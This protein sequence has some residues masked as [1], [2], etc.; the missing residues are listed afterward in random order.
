VKAGVPIDPKFLDDFYAR[1]SD[2][3]LDEDTK[4]WGELIELYANEERRHHADKTRRLWVGPR[5]AGEIYSH[6][7]TSTLFIICFV[8]GGPKSDT[9]E[10]GPSG[11]NSQVSSK[12]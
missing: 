9:R 1:L 4:F 3:V 8:A 5:D 6:T 2:V 11:T 12:S 7:S 10:P